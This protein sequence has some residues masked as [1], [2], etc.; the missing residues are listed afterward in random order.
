MSTQELIQKMTALGVVT[1]PAN[2]LQCL[3]VNAGH[4][5]AATPQ[6]PSAVEDRHRLTEENVR[7]IRR[8]HDAGEKLGFIAAK[9]GISIS[10]ACLIATR[11]RKVWVA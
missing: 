1:P 10:Y 4:A 6:R 8:M 3:R 11:Q 2:R 7:E 5:G 9:F